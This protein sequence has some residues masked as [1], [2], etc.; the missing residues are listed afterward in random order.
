MKKRIILL[1]IILLS[2]ILN[3]INSLPANAET[4]P[5]NPNPETLER[6]T[7]EQLEQ[8]INSPIIS[9]G[10]RTIDLREFLIDLTPT[11]AEFR[12]RFYPGLQN[13]LNRSGTPIALDLSYSIIQGDFE[14]NEL[15]LRAPLYGEA[16]LP[17]FS[18][19]E[20]SQLQRDRTRLAR[21][22]QLS[23]SL[24][25]VPP[26]QV[27]ITLFQEPIKLVHTHFRGEVH[28]NHSFFLNRV[29]AMGAIFDKLADWSETRF[30]KL[31]SFAGANFVGE[32]RFQ[33]SIFFQD[34]GFNQ[35]LFQGTANFKATRFEGSGNF[36]QV[37]FKQGSNFTRSQWNRNADFSGCQW[38]NAALFDRA[39]FA[40]SLFLT[41][42]TFRN[43]ASFRETAFNQSINLREASLRDRLAFSD[44]TFNNSASINVAGLRFD[45]ESA[46]I[47]GDPGQIGKKL[48]LPSLPGNETLLRQL[49]RNFRQQEQIADANQMEYLTE[50]LRQESLFHQLIGININTASRQQLIRLGLSENQADAIVRSQDERIFGSLSEVLN[51]PE[52]DLASYIQLRDRAVAGEPLSLPGWLRTAIQWLGLSALL[53]L[54]RYGTSFWL[55]F[56]VGLVAIAY[57]SLL[58]WFIDR[59]RRILPK[60]IIPTAFETPWMLSTC[61]GL[62]TTGVFAIIRTSREPLL[63]LTCLGILIIPIPTV[64]IIIL[65]KKGRYHNLIDSS[66]FVEDTGMRQLR[67]AIGRLPIIPRF[68][69]MRERY[70]PLLWNRRWNWLNYY[71]FSLNN[72]LKFGFNDIRL[73]D[74]HL[75]GIIS[76]LVW[77]QW[78]LGLLYLSLL[79]WTLSRTI[80]GLNLLIYLK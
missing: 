57:F 35:G 18:E 52:I 4:T 8:R 78:T 34:M 20:R 61:L 37:L 69:A 67:L 22:S 16:F 72:L 9:E 32:A 12:D 62:A 47:T 44:T 70:L 24:L 19:Q 3:P 80:P 43:L 7:L 55:I 31:S 49:V 75:P 6:L 27:E 50:H 66:Y 21:L 76:S 1:L 42:T 11:N 63:T 71:D 48:S 41:E 79:L 59:Y 5:L 51:L 17:L 46:R 60:P 54:T 2:L 39:K 77:Y 56:G 36:N 64:L 33:G 40:E 58:F 13:Q 74:E 28:F 30:S 65:Y 53:L 29:E 10:V 25:G 45:S 15:G 73:R 38:E 14:G 26:E 23:R 68:P